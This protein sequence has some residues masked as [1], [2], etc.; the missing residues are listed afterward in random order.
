M[1]VHYKHSR[2]PAI[3]VMRFTRLIR[4]LLLQGL[5]N[6]NIIVA[7]PL[8]TDKGSFP[9]TPFSLAMDYLQTYN[10]LVHIHVGRG[11]AA[12]KDVGVVT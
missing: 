1:Y 2:Q 5:V 3:V 11:A 7:L 9:S 12:D 4:F 8:C 10:W 6:N